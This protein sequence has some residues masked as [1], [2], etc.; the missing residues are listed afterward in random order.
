LLEVDRLGCGPGD[1]EIKVESAPRNRDG[2]EIACR[3]NGLCSA[4]LRTYVSAMVSCAAFKR[5][6][7]ESA[8]IGSVDIEGLADGAGLPLK[9][10]TCAAESGTTQDPTLVPAEAN[11][12]VALQQRESR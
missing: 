7:R 8:V 1:N 11:A 10:G 4:R 3:S 6:R 12:V 9:A 2:V 5:L